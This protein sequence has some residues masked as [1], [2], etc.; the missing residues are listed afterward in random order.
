MDHDEIKKTFETYFEK[1]KKTEGDRTAWSA[2]FTQYKGPEQFEVNLTKCPR[3][4]VFKPFAN[5]KKLPEVVGWDNFLNTLP[6]LE[7]EHGV[8]ADAFFKEMKDSL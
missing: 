7:K 6:D 3:G 5:G 8:D 4:D 2:P 1:Y